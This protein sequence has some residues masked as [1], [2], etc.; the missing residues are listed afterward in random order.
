[1]ISTVPNSRVTRADVG[2]GVVEA[3][4]GITWSSWGERIA[5][6]LGSTDSGTT[7]VTVR[8]SPVV[9]LTIADYGRN[10]SNVDDIES[11]LVAVSTTTE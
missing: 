1:M 4:V 10:P 11:Q 2:S 7:S 9:G 3:R 5:V 6:T 8:S